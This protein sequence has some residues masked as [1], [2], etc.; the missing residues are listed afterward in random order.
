V[1]K[2]PLTG[3]PDQITVHMA[4]TGGLFEGSAVNYRGARVGTITNIKVGKDGPDATVTFKNGAKVPACRRP[5]RSLSPVGEQFLDLRPKKNG[6][7]YL[8]DGDE[9]KAGA[10]DLPITVA[11]AADTSTS[12]STR[13]TTTDVKVL[14][15]E[16]NAAVTT[17]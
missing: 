11:S 7:P 13:S 8:K 14:M 15:R 12:C 10:V 6:A 4:K 17:P 9:I 5:G 3:R 1:L 2:L 16:L